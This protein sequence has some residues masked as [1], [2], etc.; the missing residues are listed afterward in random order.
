MDDVIPNSSSKE[1]KTQKNLARIDIAD[2]MSFVSGLTAEDDTICG[3]EVTVNQSGRASGIQKPK[4]RKPRN[5][6]WK[7]EPIA[8]KAYVPVP[9]PEELR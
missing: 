9:L 6:V 2:N 7:M 3:N 5:P 1:K 4:K 8:V